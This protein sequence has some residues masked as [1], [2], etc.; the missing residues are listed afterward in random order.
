MPGE[1]TESLAK[2]RRAV[3]G[4]LGVCALVVLSQRADAAGSARPEPALTLLAVALAGGSIVAR[5]LASRLDTPPRRR[6]HMGMAAQLLAGGIGGIGLAHTL[7]TG[8]ATSGLL[9]VLAGA[10]FCLRGLPG[11]VF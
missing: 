6:V 1:I 9:F 10:I 3:L 2:L 11:Q 7:R 8:D 5:Q 4:T